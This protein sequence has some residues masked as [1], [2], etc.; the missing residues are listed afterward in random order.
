MDELEAAGVD[1][2][3][4]Y[5][6]N[7]SG[8]KRNRKQ[9]NKMLAELKAG[10]V[11][12][13]TELSR[14]SRSLLHM[15]EISDIIQ[16]KGAGF[17]SLKEGEFD[18]TTAQGKLMFGML[19]VMAEW[20]RNNISEQTKSGLKAAKARGRCGGRP[21]R[22]NEKMKLVETL[23]RSGMGPTQ[24]FNYLDKTISIATIKRI[25]KEMWEREG[26]AMPQTGQI[27]S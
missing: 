1:K 22:P 4:I 7:V 16:Q 21:S 19:A 23:T 20:Q 14:L 5:H 24:I 12:L 17:K 6:E 13:F 15:I 2:R 11:I 25:R 3:N 9:L 10:D 8:T 27:D 26:R 18:T